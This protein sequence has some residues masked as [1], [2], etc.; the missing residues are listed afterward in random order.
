M[1]MSTRVLITGG[2]SGIG[3]GTAERMLAGGHRVVILDRQKP[4]SSCTAEYIEA[5]LSNPASTGR[6]LDKALAGGAILGL[7]NNVATTCPALLEDVKL[8]DIDTVMALNIRCPIQC[9]QA[10]LPGMRRAQFGRIV[11]ISS[12]ASLGKHLRTTYAASK[13]GI[14][15]MTRVWALELAPDG[16]T[17][18]T[19][20]PGPID[21]PLFRQVNTMDNPRTRSMIASIPVQRMGQPADIA[22]AVAF[23]LD[24]ASSFVTGQ[25]IF[26]DGGMSVA[27]AGADG[28]MPAVE[29]VMR[30]AAAS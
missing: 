7:V 1:A 3:L 19:V 23:F 17:V 11:N 6:A 9:A 13:A 2:A 4:L 16:I 22:N 8:E 20:A 27:L 10:V 21:T 18:N 26:V 5:D 24:Q 25:M 28:Y 14:H 15:G 30:S 12:R 29:K